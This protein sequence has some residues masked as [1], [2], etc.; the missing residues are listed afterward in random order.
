M[1]EYISY[2]LK[3]FLLIL[4]LAGILI[5]LLIFLKSKKNRHVVGFYFS[6]LFYRLGIT[7]R[8]SNSYLST[9]HVKEC[10]EPLVDIVK[11]P[12]IIVNH[13]TTEKPVLVRKSVASKIYKAAESLPDGVC[14]KIYSALRSRKS[15]YEA[16]TSEID[17]LSQENPGLGRAELLGLVSNKVSRPDSHMGGHDTGGAVDIALCDE[18]GIDLDFGSK[19]QEKRHS[20][21][22]SSEQKNNRNTLLKLMKSHNFVNYPG[23]WWHFSYGDK[24]WATY[25]GKRLGAFYASAEKEYENMGYVRII[26]TEI[27]SVTNQIN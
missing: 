19:Y 7:K 26:K 22:L 16:W 4:L 27:K 15:L 9:V 18:N 2:N 24:L 6:N 8:M 5:L 12:K 11:H 25:K 13:D 20:H 3:E 21:N 17:R 14:L 10:Y 23:Q 1:I